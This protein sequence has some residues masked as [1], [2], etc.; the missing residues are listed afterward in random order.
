MPKRKTRR[1]R[2]NKSNYVVYLDEIVQAQFR[3]RRDAILCA[4]R[5]HDANQ[6]ALVQV[7]GYGETGKYFFIE[8]QKLNV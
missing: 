2:T 7:S 3:R 5:F 4:L 1:Q 8:Y 6:E